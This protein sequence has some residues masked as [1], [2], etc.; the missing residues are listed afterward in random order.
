[1]AVVAVEDYRHQFL[2]ANFITQAVAVAAQAVAELAALVAKAVAEL[3]P[4]LQEL[5]DRLI[6]AVVEAVQATWPQAARVD[7]A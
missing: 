4:V 2:A 5:L 1:M 3:E 7:Q 6:L